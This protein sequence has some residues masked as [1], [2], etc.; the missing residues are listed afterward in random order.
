MTNGSNAATTRS[1]CAGHNAARIAVISARIG[2]R[3]GERE[4]IERERKVIP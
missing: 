4:Y 1:E 2:E 3:I